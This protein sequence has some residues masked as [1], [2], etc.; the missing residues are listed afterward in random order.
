[1]IKRKRNKLIERKFYK[2]IA[3][4][5]T[6]ASSNSYFLNI[7]KRLKIIKPIDNTTMRTDI[8]LFQKIAIKMTDQNVNLNGKN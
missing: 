6:D 4:Q 3:E 5:I 1:M 2:E 7:K 8:P